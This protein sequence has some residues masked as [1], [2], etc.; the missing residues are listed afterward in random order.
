MCRPILDYEKPINPTTTKFHLCC[1]L[2]FFNPK[3]TKSS[4]ILQ[5][6]QYLVKI[7]HFDQSRGTNYK[8]IEKSH[9]DVKRKPDLTVIQGQLQLLL[10]QYLSVTVPCALITP[11]PPTTLTTHKNHEVLLNELHCIRHQLIQPT[12]I[13]R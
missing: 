7:L 2:V 3:V 10:I 11:P 8:H 4:S 6:V 1:V 13:K 5:L 12:S 9:S